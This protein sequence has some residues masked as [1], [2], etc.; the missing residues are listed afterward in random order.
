MQGVHHLRVA[1]PPG[2]GACVGDAV[3]FC[4]SS[5]AIWMLPSSREGPA[6]MPFK[7][8]MDPPLP[9]P[10]AGHAAGA[11]APAPQA[12]DRC[13]T[14][15]LEHWWSFLTANVLQ[16]CHTGLEA[17]EAKFIYYLSAIT[18]VDELM[19]RRRATTLAFWEF[20]EVR[21]RMGW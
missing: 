5:L 11:P 1:E 8:H 20:V 4:V 3:L 16:G 6:E 13:K 15:G 19:R 12:R 7:T 9:C 18:T 17:R 2:R 21:A 10:P 14:F